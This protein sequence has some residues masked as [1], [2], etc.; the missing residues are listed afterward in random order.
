MDRDATDGEVLAYYVRELEQVGGKSVAT[1]KGSIA[2]VTLAKE[3]FRSSYSFETMLTA[4][5]QGGVTSGAPLDAV[6]IDPAT[7]KCFTELSPKE[8]PD[9]RWVFEFVRQHVGEL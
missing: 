8:R 7:G 2:L 3:V 4:E 5:Q 1:W 9:A 6:T